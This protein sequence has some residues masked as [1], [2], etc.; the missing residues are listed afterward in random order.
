MGQG[1]TGDWM[2]GNE[3]VAST[4]RVRVEGCEYHTHLHCSSLLI[5]SISRIAITYWSHTRRN[6]VWLHVWG[7]GYGSRVQ[8]ANGVMSE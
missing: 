6:T 5:K 8:S 7:I 1:G 3:T 2:A 4:E